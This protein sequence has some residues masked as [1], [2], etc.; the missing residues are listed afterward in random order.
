VRARDRYQ[1]EGT[2]LAPGGTARRST[3]FE[4]FARLAGTTRFRTGADASGFALTGFGVALEGARRTMRRMDEAGGPP[5]AE[6]DEVSIA[7]AAVV[8][9]SAAAAPSAAAGL[10]VAMPVAGAAT[11]GASSR[12]TPGSKS[13]R[14]GGARRATGGTRA[15]TTARGSPR[16]VSAS[17]LE[18]SGLDDVAGAVSWRAIMAGSGRR[19][20]GS[21]GS[22][23]SRAGAAN[24]ARRL[25]CSPRKL[26]RQSGSIRISTEKND[27]IAPVS[28]S[29][30]APNVRKGS[31]RNPLGRGGSPS[32]C[33]P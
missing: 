19:M 33:E 9:A 16:E 22:V 10:D 3:K 23:L 11:A 14:T 5:S 13:G 26:A 20:C 31:L 24:A 27:K 18:P 29:N 21:S 6:R 17:K 15:L 32:P 12:G 7:L 2:G 25:F 28:D 8:V 4:D 1:G 30:N